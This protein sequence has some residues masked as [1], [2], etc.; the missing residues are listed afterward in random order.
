MISC[1]GLNGLK[2]SYISE[3]SLSALTRYRIELWLYVTKS[4]SLEPQ[5]YL[6]RSLNILTVCFDS[7]SNNLLYNHHHFSINSWS[8]GM[9]IRN[10]NFH[11]KAKV[12]QNNAL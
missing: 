4:E 1:N 5:L 11:G 7:L 9:S 2:S 12:V 8:V 10:L 3:P 6:I